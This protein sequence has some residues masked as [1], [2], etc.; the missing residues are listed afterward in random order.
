MVWLFLHQGN[1]WLHQNVLCWRKYKLIV[2]ALYILQM[3]IRERK[4]P[5]KIFQS[6]VYIKN[7]QIYCIHYSILSR[8]FARQLKIKTNIDGT[9]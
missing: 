3:T 4:L 7:T 9:S 6:E 8:N 5:A 2:A 1:K